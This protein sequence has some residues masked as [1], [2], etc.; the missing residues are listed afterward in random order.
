MTIFTRRKTL[1]LCAAALAIPQAARAGQNHD[2]GIKSMAF[3]PKS[4]T[5]KAGDSVTWKNGDSAEHTA[6]DR[7]GGWDTGILRRGKSATIVFDTAGTY[8]YY[9]VVHPSMRGTISVT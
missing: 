9:C 8:E 7:A 4:L 3:N 6:T 5:I 2:V 1:A